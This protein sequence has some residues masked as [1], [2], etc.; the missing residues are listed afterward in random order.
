ME[1]GD[2]AKLQ[3]DYNGTR[4]IATL[5]IGGGQALAA[6][7]YGSAKSFA[8]NKDDKHFAGTG[9]VTVGPATALATVTTATLSSGAHPLA[10]KTPL[11]I[12]ALV[13]GKSP[14]GKVSF[15]S[16]GK[17][18]GSGVLNGAFQAT[19][20]APTLPAGWQTITAFYEGDVANLPGSSPLLDLQ[21]Q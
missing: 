5:T 8:P 10:L 21:V 17:L 4:Q 9:M 12:T 14:K 11:T 19:F 15:Y 13:T 16:G 18:L 2:T 7:T 1:I 6:G 20:T 3:L